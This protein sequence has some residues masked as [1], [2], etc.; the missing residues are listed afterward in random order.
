MFLGDYFKNIDKRYKNFFFSGI[1]FESK[2]I[3]KNNI[4]FA[5]KGN[6]NDGNKFIS[7]AIKK[8]SKVIVTE[9]A[10]FKLDRYAITFDAVPPGQHETKINPTAKKSGNCKILEIDH[11]KKGM[12]EN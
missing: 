1:S 12:I 6:T 3:E 8:G 10:T 2:N 11:P 4:F 5:I 7:K 9:K